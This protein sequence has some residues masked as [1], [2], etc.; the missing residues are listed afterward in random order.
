M[1][2]KLTLHPPGRPA[3]ILI[4]R[5]SESLTIGREEDNALVIDHPRVSRHHA[6]MRWDEGG[7]R[8]VDLGSKN[9]TSV[10]GLAAAGQ[11]LAPGD[12]ISVGGVMGRFELLTDDE[13]AA[14]EKD[15][16]ERRRMGA[17]RAQSIT[18]DLAPWDVLLQLIDS[19][20]DM[21]EADRGFVVV[22]GDDGR[23][24]V[25][26]TRGFSPSG[27]RDGFAGSLG[28]LERVFE[29]G[30]S[31]VVA[32]AQSEAS[33]RDRPSVIAQGLG[34]I[35]CVP[36]LHDRRIVGALYLDSRRSGSG[37]TELDLEMLE[38]L[39]DHAAV[40]LA[41]IRLDERIRAVL[42]QAGAASE[43]VVAALEHSIGRLPRP[44]PATDAGLGE[45]PVS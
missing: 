16:D 32:N 23:P 36:L 14:L 3:R 12:W 35:A 5:D 37:F 41:G 6:V 34:T 7:W 15:R 20:I 9:G 18:S 11:P 13:V 21:V 1:P 28:V 27:A 10:N 26:A 43:D 22:I 25:E 8:L 45:G 30:E 44:A 29:S 24:R 31:V 38:A 2:A 33:L 4:V 40:V 42:R 17:R 39:A 19:A